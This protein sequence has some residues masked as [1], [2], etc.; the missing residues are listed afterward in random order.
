MEQQRE[1]E[2]RQM[3]LQ[4][5]RMRVQAEQLLVYQEHARLQAQARAQAQAQAQLPTPARRGSSPPRV[6]REERREAAMRAVR[7]SA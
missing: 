4:E 2:R 7:G 3:L 5:E 6:S 1:L